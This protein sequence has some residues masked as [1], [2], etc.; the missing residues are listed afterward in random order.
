MNPALQA[1]QAYQQNSI[2]SASP[3]QLVVMLYDGAVRFLVQAAA[4]M[5]EG[6]IPVANGRLRRAEAILDELIATLDHSAGEIAEQLEAIYVFCRQHLVEAQLE[7][8]P[9]KVEAVIRLLGDL[10]ESWAAIC[11]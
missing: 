9:D 5:S 8:D 1:Q 6:S 4:A 10:R 11:P 2:M 7:Q 3:E